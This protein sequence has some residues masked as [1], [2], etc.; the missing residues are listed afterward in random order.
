[1][2]VLNLKRKEKGNKQESE[3]N[4]F[5]IFINQRYKPNQTKPGILLDG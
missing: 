5:H 2:K 1:M 3:K 4:S